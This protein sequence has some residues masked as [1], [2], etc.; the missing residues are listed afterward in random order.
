M[1]LKKSKEPDNKWMEGEKGAKTTT[2]LLQLSP[3]KKMDRLSRSK[4][5]A[6]PPVP[7]GEVRQKM[8]A[9]RS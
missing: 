4:K 1:D 6:V 9:L 5:P 3:N 8:L 7:I 2:L